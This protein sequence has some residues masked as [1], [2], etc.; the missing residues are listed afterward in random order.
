MTT[1]IYL[2]FA[3]ESTPKVIF[4]KQ[5][6]SDRSIMIHP[7]VRGT[8]MTWVSGM[9]AE[10]H[11]HGADDSA[12]TISG[13]IGKSNGV[14][15]VAADLSTNALSAPGMAAA[16]CSIECDSKILTSETFYINIRP[17]YGEG[18]IR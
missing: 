7:L 4:A 13:T 3:T 1:D 18:D 2:D 9:T 14:V 12:V 16:E 8:L 15:T 10:L 6:D 17:S 5:G 11:I